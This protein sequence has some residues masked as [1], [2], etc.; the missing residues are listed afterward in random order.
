MIYAIAAIPHIARHFF[1]GGSP[2]GAIPPLL[3]PMNQRT[4]WG[5]GKNTGEE[6]LTHVT[7]LP[8]RGFG[9]SPSYGTFSTPPQASVL[10]SFPVQKSKTEQNRSSFGGVQKSSGERFLGYVFLPHTFC[11]PPCH[12]QNETSTKEIFAMLLLQ[13]PCAMKST[14]ER[15]VRASGPKKEKTSK[16]IGFGL[17]QKTE[18]NL[19]KNAKMAPKP[20][21]G[22]TFPLFRRIFSYFQGQAESNIFPS[23]STVCK[24]GALQRQVDLQG[25][26]VKESG[27]LLN[28]KVFKWAGNS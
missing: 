2:N 28:L 4:P 10:C 3:Y 25:V 18:K 23:F 19:P 21:F 14:L 22:A 11:T 15:G 17:P 9:P 1:Q 16:H 27:I 12:G 24:L 7:P 6:N 26:F 13:V 8:K 20:Y 5:G